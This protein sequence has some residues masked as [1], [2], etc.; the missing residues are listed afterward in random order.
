MHILLP[1][2]CTI[3]Q[4]HIF[5]LQILCNSRQCSFCKKIIGINKKDIFPMSFT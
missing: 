5:I 1:K 3:K 2:C 4:Q